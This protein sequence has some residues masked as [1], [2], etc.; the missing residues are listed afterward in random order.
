MLT[1][2]LGILSRNESLSL[3]Q[4]AQEVKSSPRELESALQQM[5]HMGYVRKETHGQSC[6]ASCPSGSGSSHCSGCSFA[7]S[8]NYSF[9]VLTE[10]GKSLSES[11]IKSEN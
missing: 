5:E 6:G 7:A 11:N 1:S 3:S 9:W 4:L 2:I 8:G 10:R